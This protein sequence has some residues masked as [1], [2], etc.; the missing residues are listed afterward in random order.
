MN[1][2]ECVKCNEPGLGLCKHGRGPN[3]PCYE[4]GYSN[5]GT[6]E[7]CLCYVIG[8]TDE[9]SIARTT[10]RNSSARIRTNVLPS[11]NAVRPLPRTRQCYK[12]YIRGMLRRRRYAAGYKDNTGD[13]NQ[14]RIATTSTNAVQLNVYGGTIHHLLQGPVASG[15]ELGGSTVHD[16]S[17]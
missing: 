15:W 12:P 11:A 1:G 10:G 8:K 3:C 5:M 13:S 14:S 9:R 2:D 7:N 16:R 17:Q 6:N 4:S